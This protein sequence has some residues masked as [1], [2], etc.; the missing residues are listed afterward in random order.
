VHSPARRLALLGVVAVLALTGCSA[1]TV[2]L[3]PAADDAND[4]GCAAAIV[5]M[6]D[7][8]GDYGIRTTDAQATAAWG[9]PTIATLYCG[10][11]VP[12]VSELPC[13]QIDGV[14]W[15]REELDGLGARD[16]RADYAFTTYGTDPAV[17][18]TLD[19]DAIGPGIALDNLGL[20][21]SFLPTNGRVCTSLDN[22]VTGS[23]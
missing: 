4:P 12:Q 9:N 1:P 15:L 20:A 7:E 19:G 6:P 14:F 13:V 21:M 5:R 3:A 2:S 18:V 16:D 22:T 8:L 10:V 17:R 11:P 23:D